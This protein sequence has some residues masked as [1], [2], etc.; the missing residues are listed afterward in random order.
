MII[1]SMRKVKTFFHVF[2]NSALPQAPYYRKLLKTNFS[3]SFKY[4]LFL[5]FAVNLIFVV[6]FFIRLNPQ[7]L[8]YTKDA[9]LK[10]LKEYPDELVISL[11][12][13][14]LST[15]AD[16]PYFV[17]IDVPKEQTLIAVVDE[18][19]TP[20]EIN[21][22]QSFVLFTKNA[23]VFNK[24]KLQMQDDNVVPYESATNLTLN[25]KGVAMFEEMI[26]KLLPWLIT[27]IV[28][29]AIFIVPLFLTLGYLLYL[30]IVSFFAFLVFK[31][32]FKKHTY[33]KTLQLSLHAATIPFIL[34][35]GFMHLGGPKNPQS[36]SQM[37]LVLIAIFIFS[38]LYAAY[39]EKL[40]R[41][42][43]GKN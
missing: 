30:A 3:F 12:D 15:N 18:T 38:A 8:S 37:F 5:V 28:I 16:K 10:S 22:Y 41:S 4:F 39:L 23:I 9:V 2:L 17:W 43:P 33:K 21:Q 27:G 25:K 7:R 40:H 29:F 24:E 32:F 36:G 35:Y 34:E 20:E 42:N 31:L 14:V 26:P 13:N 1:V 6:G 11:H 19:A